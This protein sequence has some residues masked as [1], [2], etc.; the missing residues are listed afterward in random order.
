MQEIKETGTDWMRWTA[1]PVALAEG[2]QL[3]E[4]CATGA[5]GAFST[6]A[7]ASLVL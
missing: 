4:M 6:S 1:M 7:V 3:A 2:L 5:T